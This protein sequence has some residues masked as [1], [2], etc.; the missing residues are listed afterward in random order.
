VSA[1]DS[2]LFPALLRF[3]RS[4]RGLSQMDLSLTA[5][6]SS[7]HVSFLET[8]RAQPSREMVLRL[9]SALDV[10]LRDQNELLRA[11]GFPAEFAEPPTELEQLPGVAGVLTRMLAQHEPFPMVA[12]DSAYEV[13][14]ANRGA[15]ALLRRMVPAGRPLP[16]PGNLLQLLFDPALGRPSVLDWARTARMLL[17][18]AQREL[19]ARPT[20]GKLAAL[21][22]NLAEKPQTPAELGH[23]DWTVPSEPTFVVR[24]RCEGTDLSFLSTVTRFSAPQNVALD[25]LRLESFFPL[26][27]QTA[28]RCER[29]ASAS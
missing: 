2:R 19:L 6:V 23:L 10:P 14:R 29:W 15:Q 28:A 11:A 5:E 9:G 12:V 13:L 22:R 24:L 3:W 25:E 4:R 20:N 1:D 16:V 21:I 26:D 27:E 8:G 17:G 18:R 7:R